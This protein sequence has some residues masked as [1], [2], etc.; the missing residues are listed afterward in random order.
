MKIIAGGRGTGIT[1]ALVLEASQ[2]NTPIIVNTQVEKRY[3]Q[4]L[5]KK[6]L[7]YTPSVFTTS[8]VFEGK[9]RGSK[10]K[11]ICIS[12]VDSFIR[13]ALNSMGVKANVQS[14]SISL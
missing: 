4:L 6:L 8:E 13:T 14:I 9:L 7:V 1:T 2:F 12:D 10:Y 3:A 5:C 11:N